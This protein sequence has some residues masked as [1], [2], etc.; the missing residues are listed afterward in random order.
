M[1]LRCHAKTRRNNVQ[2]SRRTTTFSS[3]GYP[4]CGPHDAVGIY[5]TYCVDRTL[6]ASI[7]GDFKAGCRMELIASYRGATLEYV[8]KIIRDAL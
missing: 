2:C 1:K 8:E 7:L 6:D 3:D 4:L 5:P